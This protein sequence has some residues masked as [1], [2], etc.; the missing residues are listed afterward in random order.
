MKTVN[1]DMFSPYKGGLKNCR[2]DFPMLRQKMGEH[3]FVYFDSSA[4]TLK[5]QVVIDEICRYYTSCSLNVHRGDYA[6]AIQLENEIE[7]VRK[8]S[9]KFF[10]AKDE[11]EIIFTSGATAALNMIAYGLS[12]NLIH[13]GDVILSTQLEHASSI[14]PW[15]RV[16]EER[17]ASI[18]FFPLHEGRVDLTSFEKALHDRVK[19]LVV[20]HVSNSLGYALPL[21]E[22]T[23]LAHEKGILV[24]ADC[25]QSAPHQTLDFQDLDIDFAAIAAHKM[26]GPTGLGLMY[27]KASLLEDCKPLILGGG[28]NARFNS[29]GHL[30][31]KKAPA[32]FE[33]GTAPLASILGF[34][35]ALRYLNNL[36]MDKIHAYE[37]EL[38]SYLLKKIEG[39]Q[40]IEVYTPE[41]DTGI[42]T[43][44][45]KGIFAQDASQYFSKHGI[46]LR[47]GHHCAKMSG[48]ILG[49]DETL[50]L[51]L[52]LYNTKEEIDYF[53]DVLSTITLEQCIDLYL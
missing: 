13:S 22:M 9:A 40:H 10:H 39:M 24:I 5:P 50:R 12:E 21:K 15:F 6:L 7:Q 4:T 16:A 25:S 31:M 26:L 32:K 47:A 41:A 11:K 27:G 1:K 19:V 45:C 17:K 30:S 52:Y 48:D 53:V 34:G 14:L 42:F 2:K 18:E 38:M 49:V 44:N 36:G 23:R 8:D 29:C 46:A 51:S 3:S 37:Q 28:S 20:A 33:S 35:A 43:F